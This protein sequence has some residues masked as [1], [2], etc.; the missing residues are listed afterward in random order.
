MTTIRVNKGPSLRDAIVYYYQT[1]ENYRATLSWLMFIGA[2]SVVIKQ[3]I[4]AYSK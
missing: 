1:S 3:F 2:S 4:S